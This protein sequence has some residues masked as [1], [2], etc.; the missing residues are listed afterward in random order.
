[1]KACIN[2][3]I[4]LIVDRYVYSGIAF[5]AAKEGMSIEWCK[6]AETGL[7]KPDA[8]F[9]LSMSPDALSQRG[10][11]GNE[12]YELTEMQTKVRDNFMKLEDDTWQ[13]IDADQEVDVL[14]QDILSR[15]LSVI[16]N[17]KTK[18]LGHLW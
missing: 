15:A 14:H 6:Q 7:P 2:K 5:S 10:G 1:M 17:S 8:V 4:T 9:F 3:G 16:Q 18:S 12:R 11:F 13:V